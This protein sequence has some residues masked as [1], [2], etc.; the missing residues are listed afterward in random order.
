[1]AGWK[2]ENYIELN[3]AEKENIIEL[4]DTVF[5]ALNQEEESK[6]LYIFENDE[7]LNKISEDKRSYLDKYLY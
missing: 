4:D 6:N 7:E 1:M 3:H 5:V 2:N